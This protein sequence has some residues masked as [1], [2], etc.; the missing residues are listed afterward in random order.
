MG[1]FRRRQRLNPKGSLALFVVVFLS[2]LALI[3]VGMQMVQVSSKR[4]RQQTHLSV[5]A[6][7]VA[8]AG[9]IEAISWFRRQATQPVRS[10]S[11]PV[12]Y[13]WADAAFFPR[14][15]AIE[16]L[17][18]TMDEDI[19]LV[20]EY[21]LTE[22]TNVWGRFEI[23]RQQD[24]ATNPEDTQAVHDISHKRIEGASAG[25]G[26]A[27][28]VESTGIVFRR[29]DSGVAFNV[30]PNEVIGRARVATEI[31]RIALTLPAN[32]AVITRRRNLVT[33]SNNGRIVGGNNIGLGYYMG[34]AATVSGTGSQITGTPAQSDIDG[35]ASGTI[36]P[37]TIFGLTKNELKLT[38]DY[39]VSSVSEMPSDYP[40]MAVVYIAGNASFDAGHKL[41]GGGILFVDGNLTVAT[42]A[43]TL[44]SGL[45]YVVGTT[46]ISGPALISGAL[47][48]EGNVTLN[49]SGDVA[50]IDYDDSILNSVRQQVAQYRENKSS[51]YTFSGTK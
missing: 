35:G 36:Y 29:K 16:A 1:Q 19:G 13:P 33:C 18:D 43:N 49:G 28:Y 17:A 7:N 27:W 12:A 31:R 32:G 39:T 6:D 4:T 24:T 15:N 5:Q 50:E 9:L 20:K 10:S 46:S 40:A 8:R 34:G 30:A 21:A 3:P 51:F 48:S 38:A 11:D 41:R 47:V 25:D 42:T 14:E 37:Q 26:L 44:F 23:R 22:D 2:L 45:I